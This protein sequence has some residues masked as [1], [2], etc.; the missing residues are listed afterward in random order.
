MCPFCISALA[1]MAATEAVATGSGAILTRTLVN[2]MRGGSESSHD[3][4]QPVQQ[5]ETPVQ[6][7]V[8]S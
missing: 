8:G 5:P 2:R 4:G 3:T 7:S 6:G 1:V